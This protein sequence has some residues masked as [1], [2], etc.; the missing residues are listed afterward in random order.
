MPGM[1]CAP[2]TVKVSGDQLRINLH[3]P[4]P[5]GAVSD[6]GA[7]LNARG[8]LKRE[9]Q[10]VIRTMETTQ[11]HLV[12][13]WRE[14]LSQL[15]ALEKWG[16]PEFVPPSVLAQINRWTMV[17]PAWLFRRCVDLGR[18]SDISLYHIGCFHL[19]LPSGHSTPLAAVV[20]HSLQQQQYSLD[21]VLEAFRYA[22]AM[23]CIR[24]PKCKQ[25]E[26]KR[27]A[28]GGSAV[29]WLDLQKPILDPALSLFCPTRTLAFCMAASWFARGAK[30][31]TQWG[32]LVVSATLASHSVE[33]A[34]RYS[35]NACYE[36]GDESAL[37]L[38]LRD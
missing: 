32:L 26:G 24:V 34:K 22:G 20:L 1:D 27:R 18:P 33:E 31:A 37:P 30:D 12:Y 9:P 11:L 17:L 16:A 38:K 21:E 10:G 36:L 19:V 14:L 13:A 5:D 3:S 35:A 8:T 2:T 29:D 25:H 7:A 23:L 15:A 28:N 6:M 4:L